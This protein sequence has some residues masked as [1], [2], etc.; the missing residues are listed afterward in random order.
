MRKPRASYIA[1]TSGV[2]Q[3]TTQETGSGRRPIVAS[4]VLR[5]TSANRAVGAVSKTGTTSDRNPST[6]LNR[7]IAASRRWNGSGLRFVF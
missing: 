4:T 5:V 3:A 7:S 1:A 6:A 2:E